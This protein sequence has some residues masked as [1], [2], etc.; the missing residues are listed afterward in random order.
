MYHHDAH[1]K[2]ITFHVERYDLSVGHTNNL[3]IK[4]LTFVL[5][6][7]NNT[8][9]LIKHYSNACCSLKI[10]KYCNISLNLCK[11]FM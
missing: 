5:L 3:T 11:T 7:L 2:S 1:K 6:F 4:Q 8:Y 10:N 9:K